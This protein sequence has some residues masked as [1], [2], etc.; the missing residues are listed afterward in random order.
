[1]VYL[2]RSSINCT[3]EPSIQDK[4]DNLGQLECY[5]RQFK[6]T[7][8]AQETIWDNFRGTPDNLRQLET[9]QDNLRGT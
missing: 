9:I 4:W 6:T 2:V 5:A 7:W 3:S 1:M 8:E